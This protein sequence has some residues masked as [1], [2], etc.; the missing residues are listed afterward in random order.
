MA[1]VCTITNN[2]DKALPSG[3]TAQ[4][5]ILKDSLTLSGL[6]LGAPAPGTLTFRLWSTKTADVCSDQVG[7]DLVVTDIVA[8][9]TYAPANGIAVTAADT[10]YWTVQYSGD[11]FNTGFTTACGSE[12]TTI[13]KIE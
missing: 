2:D 12:S 9:T 4:S 11:A 13:T 10:Y 5:Y 8:N 7:S 3:S 6:R 1:V